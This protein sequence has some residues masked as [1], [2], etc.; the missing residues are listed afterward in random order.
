MQGYSHSLTQLQGYC[1][2]GEEFGDDHSL[3]ARR[4]QVVL[5]WTDNAMLM[6]APQAYIAEKYN[7]RSKVGRMT[8]CKT[9]SGQVTTI[10][11]GK[12]LGAVTLRRKHGVSHKQDRRRNPTEESNLSHGSQCASGPGTRRVPAQD[13]A[14]PGST[15][16]NVE[17]QEILCGASSLAW[18]TS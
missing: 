12:I 7:T 4:T 11:P 16:R 6:A 1:K 8:L 14:F 10:G 18:Q 3:L 15:R 2:K 5:S 13:G 17:N 9:R